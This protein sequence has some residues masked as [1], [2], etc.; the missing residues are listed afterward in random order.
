MCNSAIF[1]G[2]NPEPQILLLVFAV[3]FTDHGFNFQQVLSFLILVMFRRIFQ[4]KT[5]TK[6]NKMNSTIKK[7]LKQ[8]H[9]IIQ[10]ILTSWGSKT[11]SWCSIGGIDGLVALVTA[12]NAPETTI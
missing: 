7:K 4:W 12:Q 9:G 3:F 2:Y 5:G 8:K 1:V 10:M 11:R 6:G